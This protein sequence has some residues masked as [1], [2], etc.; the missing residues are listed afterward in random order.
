MQSLRASGVKTEG[1]LFD[2]NVK[3]QMKQADRCG[4][5][6]A[7]ILGGDEL[8]KR[9]VT[10]KDLTTGEQ[11]QIPFEALTD[12]V[13]NW[14]ETNNLLRGSYGF[15][16][17]HQTNPVRLGELLPRPRGVL[18]LTYETAAAYAKS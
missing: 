3:G 1:G 9:A 10:L 13:K 14:Y 8:A 6:Y 5:S 15:P 7:L 16:A 17:R 4:A 2:K 12:E 11:K 18:L